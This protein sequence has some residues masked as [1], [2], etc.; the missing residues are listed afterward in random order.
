MGHWTTSYLGQSQ[1]NLNNRCWTILV[2]AIR[3]CISSLLVA[4]KANICVTDNFR[5]FDDVYVK[6][7]ETDHSYSLNTFWSLLAT[8]YL[9]LIVKDTCWLTSVLLLFFCSSAEIKNNNKTLLKI[10]K[11]S[12]KKE[13]INSAYV[14]L[15]TKVTFPLQWTLLNVIAVNFING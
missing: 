2:S 13:T 6:T 7:M 1:T 3:F 4:K 9:F 11:R 15:L 8:N 5:F 14:L 10:S 12:K